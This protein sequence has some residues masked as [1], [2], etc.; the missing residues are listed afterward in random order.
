M[1]TPTVITHTVIDLEAPAASLR[2]AFVA[3]LEH[4][5]QA[6]AVLDGLTTDHHD[7]PR[8]LASW[9]AACLRLVT[10]ISNRAEALALD[11]LD[12]RS[13]DDWI[14]YLLSLGITQD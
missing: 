1:S 14:R 11:G 13:A 2:P 5:N 4:A 9:T 8:A 3:L 6:H 12:G 10:A 7:Y